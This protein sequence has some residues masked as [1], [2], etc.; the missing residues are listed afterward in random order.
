MNNQD[1]HI[2][3]M[4]TTIMNTPKTRVDVEVAAPIPPTKRIRG[5]TLK[6]IVPAKAP[7]AL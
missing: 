1:Q 2:N 7:L 5:R 4:A 3:N 6:K